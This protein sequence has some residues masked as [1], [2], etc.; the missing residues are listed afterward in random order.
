[1]PFS[2]QC[3][4]LSTKSSLLLLNC[5]AGCKTCI[6]P[7]IAPCLGEFKDKNMCVHESGA[8]AESSYPAQWMAVVYLFST[9]L[10]L[11]IGYSSGDCTN[12]AST[13]GT[14]GL[15]DDSITRLLMNLQAP[16]P[17]SFSPMF[18]PDKAESPK[19]SLSTLFSGTRAPIKT[20]LL[21]SLLVKYNT[22]FQPQ[23]TSR[24]DTSILCGYI[25]QGFILTNPW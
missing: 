4:W 15:F 19:S 23:P 10:L 22:S 14:C 17:L 1:M 6:R 9:V 24:M 13:S 12:C 25:L 20:A 5:F 16:Q 11:G 7:F 8:F 21:F 2:D 3:C 18:L